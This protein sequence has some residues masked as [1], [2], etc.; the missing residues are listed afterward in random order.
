MWCTWPGGGGGNRA[1]EDELEEAPERDTVLGGGVGERMVD[2][3]QEDVVE[4]REECAQ[5][6]AHQEPARDTWGEL[7]RVRSRRVQSPRVSG[8]GPIPHSPRLYSHRQGQG[9]GSSR[10]PRALH[11]G[12]ALQSSWL[13]GGGAPARSGKRASGAK[14]ARGQAGKTCRRKRIA[15]IANKRVEVPRAV[16]TLDLD[17]RRWASWV[18]GH[19]SDLQ[20]CGFVRYSLCFFDKGDRVSDSQRIHSPN[21]TLFFDKR[22]TLYSYD[23]A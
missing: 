22:G 23:R 19:Y 4:A 14:F 16:H 7:A 13:M 1:A 10:E 11:S 18:S 3:T 5:L 6:G 21:I 2:S 8:R 15:P 17:T 12:K 20:G 9:Q